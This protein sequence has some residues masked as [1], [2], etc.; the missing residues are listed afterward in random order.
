MPS[1]TIL[2]KTGQVIDKLGGNAALG[3]ALGVA[4]NNPSNWRA[5]GRFPAWTLPQI[6]AALWEQGKTAA[7]ALFAGKPKGKHR[8][9]R[10]RPIRQ[11]RASTRRRSIKKNGGDHGRKRM[12]KRT[13]RAPQGAME[14]G[15][16]G[17]AN[18]S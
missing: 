18:R 1:D 14:R 2:K 4:R 17:L 7:P 15:E 5:A 10:K 6:T 8:K 12:V 11:A 9:K 3:R 16:I 13:D